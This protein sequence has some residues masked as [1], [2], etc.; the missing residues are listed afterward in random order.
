MKAEQRF[1]VRI[2]VA[3]P[4]GGF[5]NQFNLMHGWLDQVAG[6][7]NYAI[8]GANE[9]GVPDAM[10]VYFMDARIAAAFVDRFACGMAGCALS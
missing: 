10:F 3:V 1:P 6:R 4:R 7:E 5:G 8:W 2:R 9:P